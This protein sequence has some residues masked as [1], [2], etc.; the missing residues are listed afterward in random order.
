MESRVSNK[1]Y[2]SPSRHSPGAAGG[3]DTAF[4]TILRAQ[5]SNL[6][7]N[8]G[9]KCCQYQNRLLDVDREL[10][11]DF[12]VKYGID[13]PEESNLVM[14]PDAIM[15]REQIYKYKKTGKDLPGFA[16]DNVKKYAQA[17]DRNR[18]D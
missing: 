9:T 13:K 8:R 17:M 3:P 18:E 15:R 7:G 2:D 12:K 14:S 10:Y 11:K 5:A 16:E 4:S 6:S 1:L